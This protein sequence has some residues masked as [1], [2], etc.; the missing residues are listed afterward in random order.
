MEKVIR[1]ILAI[2][3]GF[4]TLGVIVLIGDTIG[5]KMYPLPPD[6]DTE[7]TEAMTVAMQR[8]PTGALVAVL[9]AWALGTFVGAW[10]AARLAP[11][12]KIAMGLAIGVIGIALAVATML[13]IA[14][15]VWMWIIGVAEFVPA[16]YLGA[17]LAVPGSFS[18]VPVY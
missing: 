6:L 2:V 8:A 7:N 14:H 5:H 3:I 10:V 9:I 4:F 17:K 11:Q 18:R 16:A 13:Q 1:Y 15:P 12:Y